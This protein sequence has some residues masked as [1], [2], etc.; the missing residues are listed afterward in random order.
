MILLLAVLGGAFAGWARARAG[1]RRYQPASLSYMW[2]V[3][4]AMLP[5][6]LAIYFPFTRDVVPD[7]AVKL[8]L[9][10]SQAGLLIFV[11]VNRKHPGLWI[12]GMGLVLNLLVMGIN[13]GLMPISPEAIAQL[14]PDHSS[15]VW[16]TGVRFGWSKDIILP[17]AST[18][19]WWLSDCFL[20]PAWLPY[21]VA[22][23]LGDVLIALGAFWFL[24][25]QGNPTVIP[26]REVHGY[27]SNET[28]K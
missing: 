9:I 4:I 17:R 22:F 25:V 18:R 19:L 21:R 13:G 1:G 3:I 20:L 10:G 6:G 7:W 24:W 12:L 16:Q 11:W 28:V 5:Q 23:S 2:L 26:A 14:N 15:T 8:L 27:R